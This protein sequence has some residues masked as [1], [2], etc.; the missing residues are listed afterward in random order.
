MYG[1][2]SYRE[3]VHRLLRAEKRY[4]PSHWCPMPPNVKY[5]RAC[6]D[7]SSVEFKDLEKLFKRTMNDYVQIVKIE[8]VQ[9]LFMME[10]YC[11]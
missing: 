11:R 1:D 10:K 8:R 7:L 5:Y 9:N 3:E 4:I 6:V 2:P